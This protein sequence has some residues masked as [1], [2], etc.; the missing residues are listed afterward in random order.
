M[1]PHLETGRKQ[2]PPLPV[3]PTRFRLIRVKQDP[4]REHPAFAP[5]EHVASLIVTLITTSRPKGYVD[6][7]HPNQ[8]SPSSTHLLLRSP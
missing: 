8:S 6:N 7:E 1:L 4:P 5:G 3:A 2:P